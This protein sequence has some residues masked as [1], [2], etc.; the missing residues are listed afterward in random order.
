M[1]DLW[2][3][4]SVLDPALLAEEVLPTSVRIFSLVRKVQLLQSPENALGT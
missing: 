3:V 1:I 4:D 2:H